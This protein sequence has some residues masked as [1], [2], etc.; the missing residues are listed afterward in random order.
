MSHTFQ[1]LVVRVSDDNNFT[2]A[3]EE[4][5][6]K[7]LPQGEVLIRVYYSSLNYKDGLSCIGNRGVTR[8]YPHTPG[9]DAAGVVESSESNEFMAGDQ[10][11]IT[12]YDLGMNTAGGFGQFIRVPAGWVMPLPKGLSLRESMIYGSAGLTAGLS[13][14]V[15]QRHAVSPEDG[16]IVVTGATGGVGSVSVAILA[17][18]GYLVSASTGKTDADD[19]LKELGASEV[20][21]RDAVNDKYGKPLLKETWEGAI[22]TV[23]GSTLATLLKGCKEGGSVVATGMVGSTDLP[24][25]VFPFILRGVSLLGINSQ[26][27]SKSLR[28][29]IWTKMALEWKPEKLE[30]LA[31]DCNLEQLEPEIDRIIAGE[32]RGRVVVDMR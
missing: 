29:E 12:S 20:I 23:G 16:R 19:F 11:V 1:A 26:G 6:I 28:Q 3:I 17:S 31:I 21:G 18:L 5:R 9:I 7:D 25:T 10:V 32:Q 30:H 2:R 4:R 8:H 22:D 15:L 24:T 14:D 13:V 27:T